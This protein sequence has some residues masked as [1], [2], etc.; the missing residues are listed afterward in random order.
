MDDDLKELFDCDDALRIT[1]AF[2]NAFFK[3][4]QVP[5]SHDKIESWAD[6]RGY[7][8]TCGET[9]TDASNT[10][11]VIS[12]CDHK[13]VHKDDS[14]VIVCSQCSLEL[15]T[16]DFQQEWRWYGATGNDPSRCHRPRS[17]P[18]GI[19]TVFYNNNINI[20]PAM[21]DMVEARY[22]NITETEGNKVLRGTGRQSIVAACLFHV[23]KDMN[24]IRTSSYIRELFNITQ[25]NMS[26]AM[27]KYYKAFQDAR[28]D[29]TTPEKLI[30]W[31]MK[32]SGIDD[33]HLHHILAITR[34]IRA[35]SKL[36][37]RSNPQSVAAAIV[38]F[39]LCLKKEYK[40]KHGITKASFAK[41]A[42]LS[43]ITITKIAREIATVSRA[44]ISM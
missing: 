34:Y 44:I 35:T 5:C 2:Q 26:L 4:D 6:G 1:E 9:F 32:L 33:N 39:Y 27:T 25:K 42:K 14:G 20:S 16:L 19:R 31:I 22:N 13:H 29:H 43:E 30:P 10:D 38:F 36:L 28:V 18:R 17:T 24:E 8:V 12:N 3:E 15:K 21:M 23:Y 37:E 11:S 7:C 40:A 41:K